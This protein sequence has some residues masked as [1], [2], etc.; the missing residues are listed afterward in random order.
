MLLARLFSCE[1]HFFKEIFPVTMMYPVE[2]ECMVGPP[3][4]TWHLLAGPATAA[5]KPSS[6]SP[7]LSPLR[8]MAP[9]FTPDTSQTYLQS[10]PLLPSENQGLFR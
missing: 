2:A 7:A 10:S 3:S 8:L 1:I 5:S 9:A 4:L 6:C